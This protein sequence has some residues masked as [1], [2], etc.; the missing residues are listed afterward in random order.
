MFDVRFDLGI[1]LRCLFCRATAP[2]ADLITRRR[3]AC[4]TNSKRQSRAVV[5]DG[6]NR[7][8][9][10]RFFA[11]R[12]LLRILRLFVNVGVSAVVVP[13]EI[14]RRG[15]AA[16]IAIDALIIDVKFPGDIFRVFVCR[17]CHVLSR[18]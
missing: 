14:G 9:F 2:V 6:F 10:H 8:A 12:F 5:A 16:Q 18:W 1:N 4:P 11:H 17:I 15:F 3:R 13:L 7:A